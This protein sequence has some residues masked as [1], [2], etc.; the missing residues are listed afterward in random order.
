MNVPTSIYISHPPHHYMS[1]K[2]YNECPIDGKEYKV[3]NWKKY[4][5]HDENHIHG[6]FGPYRFLSN[7]YKA[8][9]LYDGLLYPSSETAYQAA[10]VIPELREPFTQMSDKVSKNA[11]KEVPNECL[12]PDWDDIKKDVM[13]EVVFDKFSRNEDLKQRLIDTKNKHLQETN[14][15]YD[16]YWGV[17]YKTGNGKNTLGIILMDV[18]SKL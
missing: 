3:G 14:H 6:F 9:V 2:L 8:N 17:D 15:W 4:A 7:F 11:W 10:K 18:R 13:Y 12:I 1:D 16:V 5:I